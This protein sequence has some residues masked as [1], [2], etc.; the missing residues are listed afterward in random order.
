M[1]LALETLLPIIF[2]WSSC[3]PVERFSA[4]EGAIIAGDY[5]A[6]VLE[7]ENGIDIDKSNERGQTPLMYAVGRINSVSDVENIK[8]GYKK[9]FPENT[10]ILKALL[11]AGV[12]PNIPNE[13]GKTPIFYSVYHNRLGSTWLLLMYGADPNI[14]D[15]Y[16][17]TPLYYAEFHGYTE[18]IELL[19]QADTINKTGGLEGRQLSNTDRQSEGEAAPPAL[20]STK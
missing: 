13:L 19:K 3:E 12:D 11:D 15:S 2:S 9:F 8:R 5:K 10:V 16:G 6:V 20:S 17:Y 18:L 14:K 7:L 1:C 4:L